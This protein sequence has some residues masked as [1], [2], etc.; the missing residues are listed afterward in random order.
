MFGGA[1]GGGKSDAILGDWIAHASRSNGWA[2]GIIF[3]RSTPELDEIID[4]SKQIF[5]HIGAEWRVG[6]KTWTMPCGSR[7]KMRWM[8]RDDDADLYQGHSY[9]YI[10]IDEAG[11]WKTPVALDKLRAT[12]RN[13]HGVPSV[14]RLTANPGGPGHAWLK[15]RYVDPAPPLTPFYDDERKTWRGFIPSKLGDNRRLIDADPTYID[16]IKSSGPPWLV[17]AWLDGDWDASA[18]RGGVFVCSKV[19]IEEILPAGR[20]TSTRSWDLAATEESLGNDPDYTSGVKLSRDL[21]GRFF[22][23]DVIRFRGT[24]DEVE[25]TIVATASRDGPKCIVGLPQDPGQAGKSQVL[26]LTRKLAGYRV[27]SSPESG[28]KF[29][30]ALP[31]A[32]QY[33]VGNVTLIRGPWNDTFM[34]ELSWFPDAPHDDQVDALSRAFT[35]V[36]LNRAPMQISQDALATFRA[37]R[38]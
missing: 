7:L 27:E 34:E 3:R 35:M 17:K 37:M 32:S 25:K 29:T 19:P 15:K 10:G 28:D 38:R 23:E 4:R 24:A 16:R 9:D 31:V 20:Y 33:N 14:M 21:D 26:W 2:R 22:V 5:P 8:E 1:R 12:L 18:P 30:R 13:A 11:T 36:G 6:T